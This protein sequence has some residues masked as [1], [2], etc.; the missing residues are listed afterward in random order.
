MSWIASLISTINESRI[1]RYFE[2]EWGRLS[3]DAYFTEMRKK[4]YFFKS[5]MRF[6]NLI[7][8]K[9]RC[10]VTLRYTLNEY[11][12]KS[13][14]WRFHQQWQESSVVYPQFQQDP[15]H[16]ILQLT[17]NPFGSSWEAPSALTE[18]INFLS[19]S[20]IHESRHRL[21]N[22]IFATFRSST[23]ERCRHS[24][25]SSCCCFSNKHWNCCWLVCCC[26]V[27]IYLRSG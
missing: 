12:Y 9:G 13:T 24:C 5:K 16:H 25:C 4:W 14:D 18:A 7:P 20:S 2:N 6:L 10:V 17:V 8:R 27:R 3:D 11:F 21:T 22:R 19:S 15:I 26:L 23:W 1:E